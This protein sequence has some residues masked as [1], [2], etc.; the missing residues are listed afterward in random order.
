MKQ[1][2]R[3]FIIAGVLPVAGFA[4][5]AEPGGAY[6]T[7][8]IN[9][10]F[11][12]STDGDL[13]TVEEE[14]GF[15]AITS[16][17]LS[18]VTETR[19]QRLSA[20]IA[21]SFRLSE[22]EQSFDDI[23]GRLAYTRESA[24]AA[25]NISLEASRTDIAFLRELSAFI[26][27][28]GALELPDD[29]GDLVGSGNRRLTRFATGMTWGKTDPVRY[30]LGLNL[31]A[32]RYEDASADLLD[33]DTIGASAGLRLNLNEVMTGNVSLGFS[34]TETVG[35][36]LDNDTTLTGALTFA[37]PLG[38]LTTSI[39]ATLNEE[40]DVFW[41][42]AIGQVYALPNSSFNGTLGVVEDEGSVGRLTAE[43]GYSLPRPASQIDLS[44]NHAFTPGDDRYNTTLRAGYQYDLNDVNSIRVAFDFAQERAT[45]G[46]DTVATGVFTASYGISLTDV[47]Q[48]D[49]GAQTSR[50]DDNGLKTRSNTVF[51]AI[52]RPF[53]WR[54]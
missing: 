35:E 44:A 51:V 14:D 11:Q 46:S 54:P 21:T 36:P 47:W 16:F 3:I 33:E 40:D 32:L 13:T 10:A 25:F 19:S 1:N 27:A 30:A 6:L 9:Q 12:A 37:R 28:D 24:G 17:G 50:R 48:L 22:G 20:D 52:G 4:Q 39:S 53:T 26:D 15:N 45:D 42:A 29:F 43:I 5:E 8:D 49:I 23:N 7:F 38:D 2:A 18:A 34:Q 31:Q 41:S